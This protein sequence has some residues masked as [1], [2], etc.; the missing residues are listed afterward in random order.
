MQALYS[1]ITGLTF[2]L[3]LSSVDIVNKEINIYDFVVS[4]QL[5]ITQMHEIKFSFIPT[6]F[7]KHYCV[8][9]TS[10]TVS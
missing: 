3:L 2:F 6:L 1:H 10:Q 4:I 7:R 9:C 5:Q 8:P